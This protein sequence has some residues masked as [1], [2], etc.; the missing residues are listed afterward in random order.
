MTDRSLYIYDAFLSSTVHFIKNLPMFNRII[1]ESR[2]SLNY[3]LVSYPGQNKRI[4]SV[5]GYDDKL[6]NKCPQKLR[7][8]QHMIKCFIS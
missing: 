8:L 3:W 7:S 1:T 2:L 6:S 5:N 4:A